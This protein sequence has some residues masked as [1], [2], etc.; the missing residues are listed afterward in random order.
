M[1]TTNPGT[2][3]HNDGG[4]RGDSNN[5]GGGQQEEQRRMDNSKGKA[6]AERQEDNDNNNGTPEQVAQWWE[7]QA[8]IAE[9]NEEVAWRLK[10]REQLQLCLGSTKT[11]ANDNN[12][13]SFRVPT[14][15]VNKGGEGENEVNNK[16]DSDREV[17][18]GVWQSTS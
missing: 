5:G 9:I 1:S 4:G 10:E 16:D 13:E 12:S 11:G 7:T 8:K 14:L 15:E 2:R 3:D 17:K 18:K 6:P